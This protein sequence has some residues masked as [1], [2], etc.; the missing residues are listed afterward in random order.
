VYVP[1]VDLATTYTGSS[2][3]V[4]VPE[5]GKGALT[6]LSVSDGRPL[7]SVPLEAPCY[8]AATVV[9]DLVLTADFNGLVLAFARDSGEQVWS[10]QA[11]G[12]INAPLAVAG[13]LLLVPVGLGTEASLI[14][15]RLD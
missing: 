13:D 2:S 7:W 8:G 6:A 1:V 11:P 9:A 15:L 14:A 3:P 10:Y 12:G 4:I 5:A